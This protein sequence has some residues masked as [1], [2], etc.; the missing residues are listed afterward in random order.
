MTD[1]FWECPKCNYTQ[2]NK[3]IN[4]DTGVTGTALPAKREI[5]PND[6]ADM[7]WTKKEYSDMEASLSQRLREMAVASMKDYDKIKLLEKQLAVAKK[8]L[9]RVAEQD[10]KCQQIYCSLG[11]KSTLLELDKMEKP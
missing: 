10:G 7:I 3:I 5:C 8:Y 2:F 1:R 6:G 11:A 4:P 9:D